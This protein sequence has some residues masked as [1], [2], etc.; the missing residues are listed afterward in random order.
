VTVP[1]LIVADD[2]A[3][4]ALQAFRR[5]NPG[6]VAL[7]GGSTP[8]PFYERLASAGGFDWSGLDVFF[9]DER[10][11]A[12]DHPDSSFRMVRES[13]LSKIPPPG[14][15]VWRMPGETCDAERHESALRE[16]AGRTRS[17][18]D[19]AILGLGEDGHTASLFPGDNA[20]REYE[21]WVVRVERTPHARLTLTLPVL[22]AAG[23]A[24]FL[25][26]GASKRA[27]LRRFL[28]GENIPAAR[29]EARTVLVIADP[30]AA[31]TEL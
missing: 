6:N 5:L 21:R 1:E 12:P 27:A 3:G 9:T 22:S 15:M 24:M 23:T 28:D 10:C 20:L 13:L 14:P 4:E 29:V 30:D 7:A 8:R 25:V 19:L 16:F 11:V 18:L 2:V 17:F 26:T 31:G